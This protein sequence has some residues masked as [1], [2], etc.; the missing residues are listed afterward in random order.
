MPLD[1]DHREGQQGRHHGGSPLETT[2][3]EQAD[4]AFY[5]QLAEASQSPAFVLMGDF[6]WVTCQMSAGNTAE[7]KQPS[8]FLEC[9]EDSFLTNTTG[10]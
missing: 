4:E 5:K 7:R 1:E 10:K 6:K 9:V 2:S 3:Q 8:G